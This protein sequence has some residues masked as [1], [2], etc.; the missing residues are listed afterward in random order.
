MLVDKTVR[1]ARR[2]RTWQNEH[3]LQQQLTETTGVQRIFTQAVFEEKVSL[4]S[5]TFIS[6]EA[7][8]ETST[9]STEACG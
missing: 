3:M 7:Y 5:V 2:K 9:C 6:T 8:L 1:T 4:L